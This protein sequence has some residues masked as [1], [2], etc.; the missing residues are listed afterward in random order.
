VTSDAQLEEAYNLNAGSLVVE[1]ITFEGFL[2]L[3]RHQLIQ[4]DQRNKE[5]WENPALPAN[6]HWIHWP[7]SGDF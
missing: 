2:Q 6:T 5:A 4:H 3:A 7:E 1:G